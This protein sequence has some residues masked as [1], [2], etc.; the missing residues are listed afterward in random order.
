MQEHED[1]VQFSAEER[2]IYRQA[3]HDHDIFDVEQA[4]HGATI[5]AREALLKRCAH[6][7]LDADAQDA[8]EA[9]RFLG[10]DKRA[11]IQ[12][13]QQQLEIEAT[14]AAHL[15]IWETAKHA[16]LA[17]KTQHAEAE[18]FIHGV[19]RT[20]DHAWKAKDPEQ[21][22]FEMQISL[23]DRNGVRRLRPEVHFQQPIRDTEVYPRLDCRHVV[24][25]AVARKCK[26]EAGRILTGMILGLEDF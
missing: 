5:T 17:E 7:C 13:L 23:L 10:R 16:L 26:P 15:S 2:L 25:H 8:G 6:F 12:R 4:Y 20:S 18:Q 19:Y 14:R 11:R 21:K 9:V 24:Q 22:C 3:C 1:F